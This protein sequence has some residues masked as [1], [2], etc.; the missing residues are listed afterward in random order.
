MS[1]PI[2]M[3]AL[4]E[5]VD[6]GTVTTWLKNV[7]DT[8][9]ADEPV[10]EVSTDKVDT[11]V[12][13]PAS[14]VLESIEVGEDETVS[15]GTVLGYIGDGSGAAAAEE[16]VAEEPQEEPKVE[17]PKEEPKAEAPKSGGSTGGV[18]VKMPALGESV[19]EG[20]VTTWLKQVGDEVEEDEPI[21]EV[22]TDKVDTEVPAPASGVL[23]EIKVS[24]DETVGVG[25][26]LAV[27]GGEM[28]AEAPAEEPKA[29]EPKAEAPKEEAKAEA[30]KAA[31]AAPAPAAAP[32]DGKSAYVT[33][34]V[35][36]LARELGV[37]LDS[38]S[39]T[40]VG[41]R[42]RRQDVEAAAEAAKTAAATSAPAAAPAP[43]APTAAP[44]GNVKSQ[45]AEKA[46]EAASL[47]GTRQKMTG[48]RKAI[49]K[50]MVESLQVS[51]QL[52]TV[53]EVD[54]TRIVNLRARAKESF[55]AREGVNLTYLP[56]FVQAATEA[57][58]AHPII[59]S[60]V[61]GNEIV[62]HDAEHVG[63][64]VDTERG[65]FVP[66]IKNAGDLNISGIAK[67]IADLA[68]RTREGKIKGDELSGSTFT[69][70]NTGSAGAIF[71]T[72][73]INQPNVAIMGTG[74]I[75]K[76]PGVVKDQDGNEVISI[77]SKCFLSISYDHR[78]IDGAAASR[79]LRDVKFRLEEGDFGNEVL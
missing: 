69:I 59:N 67:Q 8:V 18:E 5:S 37:D 66:V 1:E 56:F 40:G 76:A 45:I 23:T 6:E 50:H 79:Y 64:A 15:V 4:G 31:P 36:K 9:E 44:A 54:V 57:L 38:I 62:Y 20:T 2:K 29:E 30:P 72:P 63:I 12:P 51:A 48:V 22:S 39:G 73:I 28:P 58:K 75:F 71:D 42:I 16:S 49:A 46:K 21:V 43:A 25:T 52:T 27:I 55:R 32:A 70:T 14:G 7:G 17:A 74:A 33:P 35:R 65:L 41:G 60:S 3:P 19:D 11:E 24:E 47:R 13:A 34:I 53:M 77:R 68:A 78:I 26:V 10:L 61:E